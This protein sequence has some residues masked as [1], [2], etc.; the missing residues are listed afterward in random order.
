MQGL[1]RL[2][3]GGNLVYTDFFCLLMR[4]FVLSSSIIPPIDAKSE[5]NI[6]ICSFSYEWLRCTFHSFLSRQMAILLNVCVCVCYCVC[7]CVCVYVCVF[8]RARI[9]LS[10]YFDLF[11]SLFVLFVSVFH[12]LHLKKLIIPQGSFIEESLNGV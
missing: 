8:A 5:L 6:K 1:E 4:K 2:L 7:V 11:C 9:R 3:L 12:R 10:R